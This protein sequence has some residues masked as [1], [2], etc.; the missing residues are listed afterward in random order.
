[1]SSPLERL[2]ELE[3]QA[4]QQEHAKNATAPHEA[5][6][7]RRNQGLAGGLLVAA[8]LVVLKF[9]TIALLALTKLKFLL[10]GLQFLKFGAWLKTGSTMFLMIW[11]YAGFYGWKFAAGFVVLI[12]IHELG[13]G[14]AARWVGLRVG[15]PIFIPFVGAFI[16]LKDQPRSSY[17]DFIIGAGGPVA[18]TL[19]GIAC[20][21][22]SALF[23]GQAGLFLAVGYFTLVI[24]LFNLFPVWMLD[25]ARMARP[26]TLRFWI[27]GA[28]GLLLLLWRVGAGGGHPNP[29]AI[30][31][32]LLVVMRG[33]HA[34]HGQRQ[35]A[36]VRPPETALG[37]L[38]QLD[39]EAQRPPE[40][41]TVTSSQRQI[42]ALTYFSLTA[43][44]IV[45]MQ[46]L[47]SALPVFPA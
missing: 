13:H 1:M 8:G 47:W 35:G 40:E 41:S 12:L 44:L 2:R 20:I 32:L 27:I 11:A 45:L 33:I 26:L 25:G 3:E 7:G 28:L 21:G 14:A 34:W 46:F 17:H 37:R 36:A 23:P 29:T 30:I 24:N 9:K 31:L 16:A 22:L 6:A 18:G 15:T 10:A 4:R 5:G 38:E 42:A 39:A 19:G 43:I